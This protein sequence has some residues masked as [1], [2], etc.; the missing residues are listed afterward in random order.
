MFATTAGRGK[1]AAL[2]SL[3]A[4]L[5]V[6]GPSRTLAEES[7]TLGWT[8]PPDTNVTGYYVHYGLASRT[9]TNAVAAGTETNVTVFGLAEGTTYY[10]AATCY[11]DLGLESD[12]SN[13]V[14]Y[15]VPGANQ[16]PTLNALSGLTLNENAGLQ[17]VS[18][19]GISSGAANK[20]QTL[21]VTASSS[22]TGLIPNPTVTY[23][24]PNTTGSISFTPVPSASGSAII[25]VRVNDGGTSNNLISR[26]F[27]VTVNPVNQAPTLNALSGLTLNENA[28]LQ[29]VSLSGI[30][31]GAANEVQTLTVTASSSNTG[32]IPNPTVSYTSPNTT[33]SISFT[34]VP[35]AYGSATLTVSVND[36]DTS[37]N[38]VSRSFTV[39]V[40]PVNQAP[41][42]NALNGLT[43]NENAG[44]RTINLTGISSGA[45]N[46]VQTLTV[47]AS[48][49]NTGLIPNPT[50]SYT[51]PN[52][53]GSISFTPAPST[54]GSA[55]ITVRVNDGGTSNNVISRSFTVIVSAVNQPPTISA[56]PRV[57]VAV[58]S[59]TPAIACT[60]GDAETP[61]ADLI[62]SAVASNEALVGAGDIIL[63]GS[64]ATRTVTV[65][66]R[67]GCLGTTDITVS[68]SDGAAISTST[69]Q[70]SVQAKPARP[71][72]V[73][74]A[75]GGS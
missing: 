11:N 65:T 23:T 37:N 50:V 56:L 7:V 30:S 74:V 49:S 12:Y 27:T 62:L 48:S 70:L 61:P 39:T 63:G 42:L 14:S 45:A 54:A 43:L 73:R 44:L 55:I 8:P 60:I 66:P 47:T 6:P 21:T 69:F 59:R 40:N 2:I 4:A 29:T 5:A 46:E 32:L 26:S 64:G 3:L 1:P 38:L 58:N 36:G 22:N 9:Y 75:Q 71:A 25:T 35:L 33:G 72:N 19:S 15:T 28:G 52:T 68:V 57:V 13:E 10:F 41:T 20:V 51:S 17:T 67:A 53:T 24:S 31:S 34:P 16:P 18:L